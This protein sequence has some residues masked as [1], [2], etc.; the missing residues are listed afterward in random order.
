MYFYMG[1]ESASMEPTVVTV[2]VYISY[3]ISINLYMY[4]HIF[5]AKVKVVLHVGLDLNHSTGSRGKC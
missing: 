4:V 3:I 5:P 1:G 2:S